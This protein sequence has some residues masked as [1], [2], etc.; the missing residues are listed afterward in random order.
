[1]HFSILCVFVFT[2][3]SSSL[4][5]WMGIETTFYLQLDWNFSIFNFVTEY[6]FSGIVITAGA[7][8][9]HTVNIAFQTITLF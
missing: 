3:H 1:M 5:F 4:H 8:Y 9:V 6:D 2:M 7:Y